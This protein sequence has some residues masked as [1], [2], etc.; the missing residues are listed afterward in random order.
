MVQEIMKIVPVDEAIDP[1]KEWNSE[2]A[3]AW[4]DDMECED[5][6][7]PCSGYQETDVQGFATTPDESIARLF[8]DVCDLAEEDL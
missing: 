8:Q 7:D 3:H 5:G 6:L 1:E 2:A 4:F